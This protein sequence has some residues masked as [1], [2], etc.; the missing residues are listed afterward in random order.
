MSTATAVIAV[1]ILA[2][3][4][5]PITSENIKSLISSFG[6]NVDETEINSII[7]KI[8]SRSIEEIETE[9]KAQMGSI[10]PSS[11]GAQAAATE[12]VKEEVKEE[13]ESVELDD[14][15]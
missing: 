9:G 15:F 4:N 6:G 5:Q 3:N 7:E 8:G 2:G 14:F 1:Q 11:S 12:E 10:M 13:S